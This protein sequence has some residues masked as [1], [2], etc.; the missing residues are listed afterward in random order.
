MRHVLFAGSLL[1]LA[2]LLTACDPGIG[3]TV[4]N[5]SASAVCWYSSGNY[6]HGDERPDPADAD[7][8]CSLV[9]PG[10]TR[11]P[12]VV[13]CHRGN[14]KWVVLTLGEGG[15]E[16][17]ARSATCGEWE[18]SGATVTVKQRD[19]KFVITDSL[20]DASPTKEGD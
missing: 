5:E 12:S 13:L 7:E 16:I 2:A 17:Y 9:V 8:P 15:P 1:V 3:I 10:E 4:V 11:G 14:T 20:P 18:D 6:R 19:G